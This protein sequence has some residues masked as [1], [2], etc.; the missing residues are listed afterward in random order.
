MSRT[1]V[2]RGSRAR[3]LA[4][5]SDGDDVHLV[6]GRIFQPSPRLPAAADAADDQGVDDDD[7]AAGDR[8]QGEDDQ[9]R[10]THGLGIVTGEPLAGFVERAG[11]ARESGPWLWPGFEPLADGAH[12]PAVRF[13]RVQL[14]P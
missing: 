12:V 8:E 4:A 6:G 5:A 13:R 14:V 3:R 1:Q 2:E 11:V 7:A 9:D 10:L